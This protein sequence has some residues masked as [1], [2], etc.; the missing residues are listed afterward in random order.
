MPLSAQERR[1]ETWWTAARCATVLGWNQARVLRHASA[2]DFNRKRRPPG[3]RPV[4]LIRSEDVLRYA[5]SHPDDLGPTANFESHR[6]RRGDAAHNTQ[7]GVPTED[8]V[9]WRATVDLLLDRLVET[10]AE[11]VRQAQRHYDDIRAMRQV[12]GNLD[13]VTP[14]DLPDFAPLSLQRSGRDQ[15]QTDSD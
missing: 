1:D 6:L 13:V 2:G 7:G 12:V 10:A 8:A 5:E 11:S 4:W 3:E 15:R 9:T 14:T